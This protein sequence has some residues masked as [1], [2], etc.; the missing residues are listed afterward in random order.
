MPA[1]L[2]PT[3]VAHA[4]P[5]VCGSPAARRAA[6]SWTCVTLV[7]LAAWGIARWA[8]FVGYEGSDDM[9]Y[10]RFANLW[11]RVPANQWEVRLLGNLLIRISMGVVGYCEWAATIPALLSSLTVLAAV[12]VACRRLGTVR[13]AWWAGLITALLPIEVTN[14]T[15]ASAH[16]V[17]T[18][19]MAVG[20][21]AFLSANASRPAL[22]LAAFFLPLGVVAHYNGSYYV[23]SI[24]LAALA[25]DRRTYLRP[26]IAVVIGGVL[27][28]LADMLVFHLLFG[29]AFRRLR[30]C[31]PANLEPETAMAG[32]RMTWDMARWSIHQL[33]AG[34]PFGIALA[35]TFTATALRYRSLARPVRLLFV[36]AAVFWLLLNFGSYVPW[37]YRPFWRNARYM[38]PLVLPVAVCFALTL[39][40]AAGRRATGLAVATLAACLAVLAA[41]GTWGQNTR[42]SR[43]LL[44][45]A[46][47]H[48]GERFVTDVHTANEIYIINGL[49]TPA[50]VLGTADAGREHFLDPACRRITRIDPA[51]CD[52][53]LVN[54]LNVERN[55]AFAALVA[56]RLGPVEY[57]TRDELRPLCT[58]VPIISHRDWAIRKPA[59][60]VHRLRTPGTVVAGG[61]ASPRRDGRP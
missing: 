22:V 55:P 37:E 57:A 24:L 38:H 46:A 51:G 34:K 11:H 47:G 52:A 45:Y 28:M 48:P 10:I 36:T 42:V 43:E 12:L 14:A 3:Q 44:A 20:T 50:N 25:V 1:I 33:V 9:F 4:G 13:Q 15:I 2:P 35:V 18:A 41:G 40:P 30:I 17:M 56:D 60:R 6:D 61:A 31:A 58:V 8:C 16:P 54:P 39:F 59:A 23:A 5:A 53:V 26:I 7:C 19:C 49:R 32:T 29:D 27:L 21:L